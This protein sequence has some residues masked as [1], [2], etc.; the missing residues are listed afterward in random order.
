MPNF[1]DI[2]RF[3]TYEEAEDRVACDVV[4]SHPNDGAYF[5]GGTG[6]PLPDGLPGA[7]HAMEGIGEFNPVIDAQI[8]DIKLRETNAA[9][10]EALSGANPV[11][12]VRPKER[13]AVRSTV[14]PSTDV[15]VQPPKQAKLVKQ[16]DKLV[17]GSELGK[18]I[19]REDARG[20]PQQ[21]APTVYFDLEEADNPDLIEDPLFA[22]LEERALAAGLGLDDLPSPAEVGELTEVLKELGFTSAIE[23]TKLKKAIRDRQSWSL[24][25][26]NNEMGQERGKGQPACCTGA[27]G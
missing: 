22:R 19:H 27:V 25:I 24:G 1:K 12:W 17:L 16:Q 15:Q 13:S 4:S 2:K 11:Q 14:L 23:R 5:T 6:A 8:M 9:L 10:E 26:M 18:C 20:Q 3:L 21:Q 7:W